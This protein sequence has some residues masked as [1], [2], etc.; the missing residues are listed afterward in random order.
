MTDQAGVVHA[1]RRADRES[2]RRFGLGSSHLLAIAE[3]HSKM[4]SSAR[5]PARVEPFL[6][7]KMPSK[8]TL[9]LYILNP[10][11]DEL[12]LFCVRKELF[13]GLSDVFGLDSSS[14]IIIGTR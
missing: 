3:K 8:D 11:L 10:E 13:Q 9:P 12:L 14:F 2:H 5:I 7:K 1:D 6:P 4:V